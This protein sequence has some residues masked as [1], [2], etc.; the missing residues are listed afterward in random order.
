MGSLGLIEVKGLAAGFSALDTMLKT[1]DIRYLTSEKNLGDG[2]VTIIIEGNTSAVEVALST[3]K[4][5][6]ASI[7]N[8]LT[9]V[10]ILNPHQDTLA[11]LKEHPQTDGLINNISDSRAIG[12]IEIYGFAAALLA[13]DA[14]LKAADI[15][16]IGLDKTK[17]IRPDTP[18]L[19]MFLKLWGTVDA[20]KT[21]VEVARNTISNITGV[22]S[23][24]VI[25]KPDDH[26]Y[27][28]LNI[29]I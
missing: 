23:S 18:G 2:L 24:S 21:A 13:T 10:S 1:V 9:V 20:V 27:K 8:I 19:I 12:L 29:N 11:L 22:I 4:K 6:A 26:I 28:F 16:I 17:S 15:S 7:G 14:A 5:T 3:G 25:A